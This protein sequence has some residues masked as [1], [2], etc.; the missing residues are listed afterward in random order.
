MLTLKVPPE[1]M[2]LPDRLL[3]S[4]RALRSPCTRI[5]ALLFGLTF[6]AHGSACNGPHALL[7]QNPTDL[8]VFDIERP[9]SAE[10]IPSSAPRKPPQIV[11][12]DA[13]PLS[14]EPS[15]S[16]T[17]SG[18]PMTNALDG[19][20]TT[21]WYSGQD[22]SV[23]KGTSPF[24]Q[25]TFPTAR[26]VRRVSILGNRDPSYFDG[27]AILHARLDVFDDAG[28]LLQSLRADGQGDRRDYTFELGSVE[29]VKAVR[30]TSL[31]DEGNRNLWG[32]IAIAE[33]R[34]E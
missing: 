2:D 15:A 29:G 31:G 30:F 14:G 8:S 3:N 34:V 16:S 7:P 23:G 4:R 1:P 11:A 33:V 13:L 24:F 25:I 5:R 28:H 9:A 17:F 22:D 21:S 10:A 18:W 27:F 12:R 19:D 20:E 26:S 32:D 6:A